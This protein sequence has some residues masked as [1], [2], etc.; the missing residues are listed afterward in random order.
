[1]P[2]LTAERRARLESTLARKE[3]QLS[4]LYTAIDNFDGVASYKFDSGEGMQQTKYR[5]YKELQDII[6]RV[7]AEIERLSRILGGK[8]LQNIVLR[9]K[10]YQHSCPA[11]RRRC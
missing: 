10:T 3:T 5:D 1:M 2:C 8:G 9:R 6:D 4:N 7:E 11:P